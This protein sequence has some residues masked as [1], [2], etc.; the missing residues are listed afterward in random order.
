M[1]GT[2]IYDRAAVVSEGY[3]PINTRSQGVGVVS[4]RGGLRSR[5]RMDW[6]AVC[7][8]SVRTVLRKSGKGGWVDEQGDGHGRVGAGG[9]KELIVSIGHEG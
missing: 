9:G 3:R 1:I 4:G 5:D 8:R 7:A 2:D 6:Q